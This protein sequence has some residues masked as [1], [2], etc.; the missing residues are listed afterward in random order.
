MGCCGHPVTG[1][2]WSEVDAWL[3]PL[4]GALTPEHLALVDGY[5]PP[6]RI[7]EEPLAG[8]YVPWELTGCAYHAEAG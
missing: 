4:T 3:D 1:P 6:D 8:R 7:A 5:Q 2:D